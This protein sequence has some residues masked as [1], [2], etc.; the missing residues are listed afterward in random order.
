[1]LTTQLTVTNV[2]LIL[3]EI[4]AFDKEAQS[5]LRRE[6][7]DAVNVIKS[8]ASGQFPDLALSKWGPWNQD[9]RDL[10]YSG[11]AVTPTL[12]ARSSLKRVNGLYRARGSV[13][14]KSP[15]GAIWSLAGSSTTDAPFVRNIRDKYQSKSWPRALGPAW[16]RNIDKVRQAIADAITKAASAVGR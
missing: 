16:N 6:I 9:G 3:R 1:M 15:G 11:F 14:V 12:R 5:T 8:E 10:S 4:N 13:V 2:D 7:K